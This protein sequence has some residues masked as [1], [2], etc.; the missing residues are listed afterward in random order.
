MA[1]MTIKIETDELEVL[2]I[3]GPATNLS[4]MV[5]LHEGLGSVAMWRDWPA[6]LCQDT[7]RCGWVYSRRGY[8]AS[9]SI[10]EVRSSPTERKGV[11]VGRHTPGYMH[12][13]AWG[14]LPALLKALAIR[15]PVL[16][17]HSDGAS[18]ALLY[19]SRFTVATCIA[20]APHVMVEDI[21]IGAIER[22]RAE[23]E[24]GALRNRLAQYHSD[25]D[26]AFWQ[27][28]DI[29]LDPAFRNFDIRNDCRQITSPVLA[30][31]GL[32]DSYGSMRQI[33]EVQP[34]GLIERVSLQSCGHS[35]QRDQPLK[36]RQIISR[37]L[38]TIT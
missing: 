27:W 16:L 29:W 3:K 32:D 37:F 26:C 9:T 20:L 6:K 36:T 13:E 2:E 33:E 23:F 17:G 38:Q 8:G 10:P 7:G 1:L 34:A 35:P 21:T 22:A 25:V 24:N 18:I 30:L 28:N 11:R 19:A 4:P 12:R 31:Q 5:F 15:E 14:T